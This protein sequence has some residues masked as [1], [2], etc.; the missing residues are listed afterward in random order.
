MKKSGG[1]PR[2]NNVGMQVKYEEKIKELKKTCKPGTEEYRIRMWEID[3]E[4]HS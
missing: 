1:E 3:R 4:I 2:H